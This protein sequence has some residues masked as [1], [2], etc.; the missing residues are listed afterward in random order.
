MRS[1]I[2]FD[3][4]IGR[5]LIVTATDF[6]F[7]QARAFYFS[8]LMDQFKKKDEQ[9]AY[10]DQR[11]A[12]CGAI[13]SQEELLTALSASSAIPLAFPPVEIEYT[14]YGQ[15]VKSYFVDGGVGNNVPTREAAYFLRFLEA[16]AIGIAGDTYHPGNNE[17]H[18][19]LA[20]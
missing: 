6:V 3:N 7:A 15:K 9:R 2:S 13:A 17:S 5:H 16:G 14:R 20:A 19:V 12:H 18:T 8:A 10:D 1:R 11:L 4:L